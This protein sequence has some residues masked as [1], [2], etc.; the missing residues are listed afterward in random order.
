MLK[1]LIV[2]V[3]KMLV[4]LSSYVEAS[5][6]DTFRPDLVVIMTAIGNSLA[7]NIWEANVKGKAKPSPTSPRYY[8][9]IIGLS[10]CLSVDLHS[11][12]V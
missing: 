1:A 11:D 7:N 4:H 10:V 12:A 6:M 2:H 3:N 5:L 9:F 8:S